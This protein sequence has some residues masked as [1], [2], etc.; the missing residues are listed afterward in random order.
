LE[1]VRYVHLN[2]I[3]A[4]LVSGMEALD[5][6][7]YSGHRAIIGNEARDWQETEAVLRLFSDKRSVTRKRYRRFVVK[8]MWASL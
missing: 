4:A 1:L 6:Y 3:R 5:G 8:G 7:R 2:L